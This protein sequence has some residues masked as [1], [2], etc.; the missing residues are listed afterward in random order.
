[1]DVVTLVN[2]AVSGVT[3]AVKAFAFADVVIRPSKA[4]AAVNKLPKIFWL[5][6][7]FLAL[8][9]Q[10]AVGLSN[11]FA[12]SWY[13]FGT[14]QLIGIIVALVYIFGIRP[15]VLRYSPRK[16]KGRGSS[17]DGPYGPW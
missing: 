5:I 6:V 10:V 17:S 11:G 3:L 13:A 8:A 1:M 2:Y 7:T 9:V 14:L 12:A 4:F 16:G 15:E